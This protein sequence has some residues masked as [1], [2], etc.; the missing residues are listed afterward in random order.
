[1][2]EVVLEDEHFNALVQLPKLKAFN[3]ALTI[4]KEAI[5]K[6]NADVEA[7]ELLKDKSKL[8]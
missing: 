6:D 5:D 3:E 1:M 4:T 8:E 7:N 2:L